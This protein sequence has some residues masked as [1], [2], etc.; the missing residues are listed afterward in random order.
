MTRPASINPIE[1]ASAI[2]ETIVAARRD[3]HAHPELGME[4]RRT[5]EVVA[6]ELERLGVEVHRGIGETGVVGVVRGARSGPG[7]TIGLRADMDALPITEIGEGRP[8]I[9]REIGVAHSCGHDAH[10]AGLLGAARLLVDDRDFTGSVALVFQPGEE[11]GGGARR[12]IADGLFRR[13]PMDA[14]FGLH[15]WPDLPAGRIAVH[16]GPVMAACD[17]FTVTT[18]GRGGHAAAPHRSV[19]PVLTAGHILTAAQGVIARGVDPFEAAVLSVT[20]LEAGTAFN[21]IP[22]RA[23]LSGTMRS[24]SRDVRAE[25]IDR[26]KRIAE[27]AALGFGATVEVE[28]VSMAGAVVNDPHWGDRAAEA[29]GRI[30]GGE[31]VVRDLRPSMTAEDFS[32]FTD[33][34]PGAYALIGL[35]GGPGLHDPAFDSGDEAPVL[36]AAYWRSLVETI[37]R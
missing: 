6:R 25:M 11:G 26:L 35:G 32:A 4:V 13:F 22:D 14:I 1:R 19:D 30:V 8:H 33:E 9:S 36:A 16:R 15:V 29:A 23:T 31:N 20:R 18:V 2:R 5:A 10:V 34:V 17:S 12:M 21:V 37:L 7:R 3:F 24:F 27:G 28:V